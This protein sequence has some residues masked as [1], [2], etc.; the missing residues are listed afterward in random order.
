MYMHKKS[1][2]GK[3]RRKILFQDESVDAIGIITFPSNRANSHGWPL[4]LLLAFSIQAQLPRYQSH[5][6]TE[7]EEV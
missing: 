7:S 6:V 4:L 3:E 2:E 5:L 1:L